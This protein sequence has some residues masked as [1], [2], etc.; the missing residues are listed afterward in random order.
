MILLFETFYLNCYS[1]GNVTGGNNSYSVAGGLVGT[2]GLMSTYT[3]SISN[4]YA[5]GTVTSGGIL[6]GGFAGMADY[7]G[8]HTT[9]TN[10]SWWTGAYTYAIGYDGKIFG[11]R[12]DVERRDLECHRFMRHRVDQPSYC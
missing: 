4:S 6:T 8:A 1:I 10:C 9:I 12:Y 11:S 7:N 5:T 3:S 2:T